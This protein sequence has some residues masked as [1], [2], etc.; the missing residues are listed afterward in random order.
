MKPIFLKK[1]R[2]KTHPFLFFIIVLC[3]YSLNVAQAQSSQNAR[4]VFQHGY[5]EQALEFW[6]SALTTTSDTNQRLKLL[7]NIA[8]AYRHLGLSNQALKTLETAL[9]RVPRN[10]I[11]HA[12]LLNELSQLHL[13]QGKTGFENAKQTAEKAHNL[14]RQINH[15]QALAIV[16]RHWGNLLTVEDDYEGA[17]EAYTKALSLVTP[18]LSPLSASSL[19]QK[20]TENLMP[21]AIGNAQELYGKLLTNQAQTTFFIDLERMNEYDDAKE[22]FSVS[23]K[24]LEQALKATQ[25]WEDAFSE[26]FALIALGQL[27]N[28]IQTQVKVPFAKLTNLAYQALNR[29]RL[30]AE[31]INNE[32]AKT[33]TYGYLGK[34]YEVSHQNDEALTLTR[35][36]L[37]SAQKIHDDVALYHWWRQLG[38]IH[39]TKGN[40]HEAIIALRQSVNKM[41]H[42]LTREKIVTM[43]YLNNTFRERIS[44]AYFE[45][46]DLLLQQAKTTQAATQRYKLLQ[47]ARDTIELFKQAELQDYFQSECI[48]FQS[49]CTPLEQAIDAQTAVFYPIALP[50]RLEILL[51]LPHTKELTQITVPVGEKVLRRSIAFF[52][53]PLRRHPESYV[54]S[55]EQE[56]EDEEVFC[57]PSQWRG[58]PSTTVPTQAQAFYKPA[59]KLYQWLIQP[60]KDTLTA[61]NITTLIIVPEGVLR[62]MPFSA[63]HDGQQ[64]LIENYALAVTPGVCFSKLSQWKRDINN[65]LVSGLSEEVQ[66]FSSLPCAE[67]EVN[68]LQKRHNL[69]STQYQPLFNQTFTYPNMRQKVDQTNYSILHIASHGQ[70]KSNLEDTFLLTYD[71][72]LSMN[73]LERI[74]RGTALQQKQVELLTLSACQTA[75]GNDRAALGLAGIALKAGVKSALASLWKVDDAATPAMILEFYRQLQN[76]NISKAQALQM[77]QKMMLND[78]KYALFRHPYYW[79]AFLL[80]GNW[81]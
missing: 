38:Q 66:G 62:T 2:L 18:L 35:H 50:D 44:P 75:V 19:S 67:Y 8:V 17:L 42:P 33:Y 11:I 72:K 52:L 36:A 57:K 58:L 54:R 37:F 65:M 15:P 70:F 51:S 53:S 26:A 55:E 14:A 74:V 1:S 68:T 5:Y 60:I 22:A 25:N 69:Q 34:L 81:L 23:I 10:T 24:A 49:E 61:H 43:G 12:L 31:R 46:A 79:S 76:P 28:E 41:N 63:L 29:A 6:Q 80:I 78:E 45:L 7:F 4:Q 20:T 9:S 56:G 27:T 3:L 64:F 59:Q 13:S 30:V 16:L 48:S 39:Q 47:Q 21:V 40:T 73:R 32:H 77:A 71:D